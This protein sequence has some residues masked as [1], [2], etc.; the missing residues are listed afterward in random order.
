MTRPACTRTGRSSRDTENTESEK[1]LRRRRLLLQATVRLCLCQAI[2]ALDPVGTRFLL[3][4]TANDRKDRQ[5]VIILIA[6]LKTARPGPH[7][8]ISFLT[9]RRQNLAG[10]LLVGHLSRS[11]DATLGQTVDAQLIGI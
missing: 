7:Y 9:I 5:R 10:G 11:F 2:K 1:P 6:C 3:L 8:T 4:I